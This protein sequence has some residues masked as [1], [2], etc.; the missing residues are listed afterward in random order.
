MK[1]QESKVLLTGASGGIGSACARALIEA[2][3][4]VMLTGRSP[5]RL[6]AQARE[7][8]KEC[9]AERQRIEWYAADLTRVNS[10]AP[11]GEVAAEWGCNVLIHGAGM[12]AFGRFESFDAN[13]MATVMYMNLFSPMLLTQTLLPH[14]RC[15]PKAQVMF[16]GS[17]LG[18]LGLPGFSVYSAGKFGLRGFAEALRREIAESSV[19]VQYLGPRSTSTKFNSDAAKRYNQATGAGVDD[20]ETVAK[21]LVQFL[22]SGKAERFLGFP[23]S[24]AVRLNGFA[25]TLLDGAFSTHR[26]SLDPLVHPAPLTFGQV[27]DRTHHT[28]DQHSLRSADL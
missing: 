15:Q 14:L 6:A 13:T 24:I 12:P 11:L 25:P 16:I 19:K 3:A 17:V 18:K 26:Q 2:G 10:L 22:E 21:A 27:I 20:V 5:A 7:L 8:K 28:P 1:A 4:S 23:E 9:Q